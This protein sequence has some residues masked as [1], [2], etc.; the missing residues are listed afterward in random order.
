MGKKVPGPSGRYSPQK[1]YPPPKILKSLT[2]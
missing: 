1:G 2:P